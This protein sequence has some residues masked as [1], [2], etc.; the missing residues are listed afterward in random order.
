MTGLRSPSGRLA[1]VCRQNDVGRQIA[2]LKLPQRQHSVNRRLTFSLHQVCAGVGSTGSTELNDVF[3][4]GSIHQRTIISGFL[5]PQALLKLCD[6]L[7]CLASIVFVMQIFRGIGTYDST[8]A[9]PSWY[10]QS[11]KAASDKAA[12]LNIVQFGRI[13]LSGSSSLL[14]LPRKTTAVCSLRPKGAGVR[15]RCFH[16]LSCG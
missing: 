6:Y 12:L 10:S 9:A 7:E 16:E 15:S 3:G 2:G 1:Q 13:D 4:K 5:S 11:E 8:T 14:W